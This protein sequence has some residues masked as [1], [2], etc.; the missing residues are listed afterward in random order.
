LHQSELVDLVSRFA[1]EDGLHANSVPGLH[2]IRASAPAQRLPTV[3]QP[4]LCIVAQGRK[5]AAAMGQL[6]TYDA[7]H[8]LVI[9][10]PMPSVGQILDATPDKPYL[11]VR[12]SIDPREVGGLILQ[13]DAA[14]SRQLQARAPRGLQLW[15]VS[16][17]LLDAVLR[18]LRL[19]TT[20]RDL[21]VLAPMAVREIYYH[22][23]TGEL[24]PRL[25]ELATADSHAQRIARAIN[26]L[27]RRYAEPVRIEELAES[28]HMSASNLH[29]HF[30][31]ITAMS[32]L[33]FQK[34]LRLHQARRFMLTDGL[35]AAA[36]GHRVGYES[37]SQFSREYR[38]LFGAPPRAEIQQLKGLEPA[39]ATR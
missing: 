34:Q 11:C 30:K 2:L 25:R 6:L 28:V 39:T 21:P 20:P 13:S 22:V 23:L 16:A 7:L 29:R 10:V 36:A 3:Y 1:P 8:C 14:H 12:L 31:Q 35:D 32:P 9:S 4:G 37:P 38:R 27:Q 5:Q 33:Q 17:P 15:R 19:L 26:L 18:L 24:G